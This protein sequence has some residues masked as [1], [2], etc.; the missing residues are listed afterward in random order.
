MLWVVNNI[1]LNWLNLFIVMFY[2][3]I[4]E[5]ILMCWGL[6]LLFV[7]IVWKVFK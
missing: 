4:I 6:M 2:G 7:W 5:E 3:G 1:E